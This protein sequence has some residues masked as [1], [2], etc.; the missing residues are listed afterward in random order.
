MNKKVVQ[1]AEQIRAQYQDVDTVL[2]FG[3]ATTEA[4]T[5]ESDIDIFLIDDQFHDSR[6]NIIIDGIATEIQQDHY[7]NLSKDIESERGRLLNRNIAT[8]IA[9]SEIISTKSPKKLE[10]LK[11]LAIDVLKSTTVYSKQDI[12]MWRYSIQDYIAKASKDVKRDDTVAFYFDAHYVIQNALEL[13]LAT[14]G[15]YLPQP[16]HLAKLLQD[17]DPTLLQILQSYISAPSLSQKLSAL[18]A[19]I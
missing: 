4:W 1:I 12:K 5:P 13:S 17:I 14:H 9:T 11:A 10:S 3:S 6:T 7:G 2:L 18:S 16:K 8:M 19:L 15:V